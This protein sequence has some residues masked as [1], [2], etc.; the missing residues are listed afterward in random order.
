MNKQITSFDQLRVWQESHRLTLSIYLLTRDF[1]KKELY[2][3][4]SQLRR[5]A[6]SVPANIVEGFYRNTT[7]EFIQ[8]LFNARGSAGEVVYFLILAGDLEYMNEEDCRKLKTD[9]DVL[10]RSL[11]SLIKSLRNK[12][13]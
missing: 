2:G 5:A 13:K 7:K 4:V 10:I 8:F 3:L 1:P 6:S 11:N 9:Y 12:V